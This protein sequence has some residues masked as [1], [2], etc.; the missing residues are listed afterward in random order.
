MNKSSV[1][2]WVSLW[3]KGGVEGA[4]R[5]NWASLQQTRQSSIFKQ[6]KTNVFVCLCIIWHW[7]W[8]KKSTSTE[9]NLN[10]ISI[11]K[12]WL[13]HWTLKTMCTRFNSHS[14]CFSQATSAH[15]KGARGRGGNNRQQYL[16]LKNDSCVQNGVRDLRN[17]QKK[18]SFS[19]IPSQ[20]GEDDSAT[21]TTYSIWYSNILTWLS[22]CQ[23]LHHHSPKTRRVLKDR[24]KG[25]Y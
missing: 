3:T 22:F 23:D 21:S 25:L 20:K 16:S 2:V 7:S 8:P 4:G 9:E 14:Q 6:E 24:I 10:L 1:K 11:S 18:G 5:Y 15:S 13:V 12:F 17:A 19:G